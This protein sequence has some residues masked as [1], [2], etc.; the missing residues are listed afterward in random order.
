MIERRGIIERHHLQGRFDV[1]RQDNFDSFI[2]CNDCGSVVVDEKTH[3]R[4]HDD[5]KPKAKASFVIH[6]P[7]NTTHIQFI[8]GSTVDLPEDTFQA[9]NFEELM[10]EFVNGTNERLAPFYEGASWK[11]GFADDDEGG[12]ARDPNTEVAGA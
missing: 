8:D 10:F 6:N 7:D 2:V 1:V 11:I 4:F 5:Y 9:E 12:E 3:D